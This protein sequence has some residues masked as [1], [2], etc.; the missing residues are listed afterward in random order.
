MFLGLNVLPQTAK[1]SFGTSLR[2]RADG[3][4][5]QE[6]VASLMGFKLLMRYRGGGCCAERLLL[7]S[8][9]LFRYVM[10]RTLEFRVAD[11]YNLDTLDGGHLCF[12]PLVWK[13]HFAV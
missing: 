7:L 8:P 6:T 11:W 5:L 13:R 2:G 12:Q 10:S 1:A 3:N 4:V 9:F